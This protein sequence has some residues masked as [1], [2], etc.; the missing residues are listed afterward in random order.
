MK[1]ISVLHEYADEIER[2]LRLK[3]HPLA[4][5]LLKKGRGDP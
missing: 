4:L 2:L 3:T 5:K 1:T